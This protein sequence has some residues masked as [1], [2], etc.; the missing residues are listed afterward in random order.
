MKLIHEPWANC[1]H[2]K[3]MESK[4]RPTCVATKKQKNDQVWSFDVATIWR[5]YPTGTVQ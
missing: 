5:T 2:V 4:T 1:H 3:D